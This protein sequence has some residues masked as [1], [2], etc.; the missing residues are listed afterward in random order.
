MIAVVQVGVRKNGRVREAAGP[1]VSISQQRLPA[2]ADWK[3]QQL[4]VAVSMG[5]I[6]RALIDAEA[7]SEELDTVEFMVDFEIDQPQEEPHVNDSPEPVVEDV[8]IWLG[9]FKAQIR[10]A[11]KPYHQAVTAVLTIGDRL[12]SDVLI[13]IDDATAKA[14]LTW[15]DDHGDTDAPAPNGYVPDFQ[16]DNPAVLTVDST[17][18]I[19]P[20]AEGVAN[21]SAP[22]HDTNG[23]PIPLPSGQGSF[24]AGSV[25]V[26]V[27][28]GLAVAATETVTP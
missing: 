4:A 23:N 28:P 11:P 20:V 6:R 18:Q 12:M 25:S 26:T 24:Q 7:D 2:P 13:T 19:V 22:I 15:V 14:A 3:Q 27:G 5:E 8:E 9:P 17:G 10:R 1:H 16:S 21:V